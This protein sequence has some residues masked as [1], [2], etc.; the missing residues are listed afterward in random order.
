MA[1]IRKEPNEVV[2]ELFE[3]GIE[4]A[5]K[6]DQTNDVAIGYQHFGEFW[7]RRGDRELALENIE[8]SIEYFDAWGA[9]AKANQLRQ[10]Y[11]DLLPGTFLVDHDTTDHDGKP[12][13]PM[14]LSDKSTVVSFASYTS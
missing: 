2:T 13:E 1:E 3:S 14:A 11:Q 7:L 9:P 4:L 10:K 6:R 8:K 12:L 5:K